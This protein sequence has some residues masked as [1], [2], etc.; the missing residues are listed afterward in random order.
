VRI[1]R[2]GELLPEDRFEAWADGPRSRLRELH[3]LLCLE[4]AE[5]HAEAGHVTV[6]AGRI[7]A[8]PVRLRAVVR[9]GTAILRRRDVANGETR[10]LVG[11]AARARV[12]V[13]R[14]V[15]RLPR[16]AQ[17]FVDR[18]ARGRVLYRVRAC[19]ARDCSR[20]AGPLRV[21]ARR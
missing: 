16:N 20:Y 19:N 13:F 11:R 6:A 9:R 5:L 21:H 18:T 2:Y 12:P 4:L 3:G 10:Y 8:A 14:T 15:G 1:D 17:A 7:P